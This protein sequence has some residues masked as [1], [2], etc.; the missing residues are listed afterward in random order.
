MTRREM[1]AQEFDE[2]FD[3]GGDISELMDVESIH[4]PA[5]DDAT[6]KVCLTMPEWMIDELDARARHYA[7]SRQSIINLWLAE[8]LAREVRANPLGSDYGNRREGLAKGV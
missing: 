7:V 6:R 3:A 1:T 4:H 8:R 5:L 2:Y